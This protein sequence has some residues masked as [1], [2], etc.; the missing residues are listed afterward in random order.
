MSFSQ[1][2]A[3]PLK[4]Q[5]RVRGENQPLRYLTQHQRTTPRP[6]E[7]RSPLLCTTSQECPTDFYR[8]NMKNASGEFPSLQEGAKEEKTSPVIRK[9][10]HTL[11]SA[12]LPE[13]L[14]NPPNSEHN[15]HKIGE[16]D[17]NQSLLCQQSSKLK[18]YTELSN[19][20]G[21]QI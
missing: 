14:R 11:F 1:L 16:P 2:L 17:V 5:A 3:H 18:L 15:P 10:V 6:G 9:H 13:L 20:T 8:S 7:M 21:T 4:D 19:K 12:N